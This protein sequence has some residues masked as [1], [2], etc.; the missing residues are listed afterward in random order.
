MLGKVR[1]LTYLGRNIDAIATT[2]Q[3]IAERWFVG[4]ARYWRALNESELDLQRGGLGRRR[5]RGEAG[6]QRPGA[7]AC[8]PDR[9]PPAAAGRVAGE[10]RGIA[11]AQSERLRNGVL[12]RRRARG[13]AILGADRRGAARRRPLPRGQRDR[14]PPGDRLDPGV[15]R[16]AGAQGGQD[17]PPRAVRRQGTPAARHVVVRH[18]GGVLQPVAQDRSAAVRREGR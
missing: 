9:L 17:C 16:S 14:V 10:V 13:A 4:D 2:D 6:G 5:G 7:E 3:L 12:S 15:E 1:A 18:R 11:H 8:R